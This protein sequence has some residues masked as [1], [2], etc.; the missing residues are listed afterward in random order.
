MIVG[1]TGGI[2]SG[3]S[4][5]AKV[6]EMLGCAL[7][8]SD[9]AAKKVYNEP[10]VRQKVINLLGEES[11]SGIQLN[12]QHIGSI[13][14][15]NPDLLMS[16]NSIIHPA[17]GVKFK[18]FVADNPGKIIIKETALL[19][20]AK[21]EKQVDKIILVTANEELR[22]NRVMQRDSLSREQVISRM[23][24]QLPEQEKIKR[25]D[26]IIYN[27]EDRFI[28]TQVIDIFGQLKNNA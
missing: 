10:E 17:V 4:I 13:I 14:F 15:N 26:F 28:I 11:Y 23:K 7:F 5:V 2:G 27:N 9:E 20:E 6:F 24:S 16:L 3:K 12:K 25:A 22:I 19:F 21:I 18:K 1:L 8:N